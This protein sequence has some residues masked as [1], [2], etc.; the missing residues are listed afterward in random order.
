MCSFLVKLVHLGTLH[1]G[2]VLFENGLLLCLV[3]NCTSDHHGFAVFIE[4]ELFSLLL[5][6][7]ICC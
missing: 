6:A 5:D 1:I 4:T 3:E 7:T 2:N